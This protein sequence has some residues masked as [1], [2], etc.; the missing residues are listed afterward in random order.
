LASVALIPSKAAAV[1]E[2]VTT[3]NVGTD[4]APRYRGSNPRPSAAPPPIGG[5]FMTDEAP[6]LQ[7]P[8]NALGGYGRHVLIGLMDALPAFEPQREG[9]RVGKVLGIGGRELV[10]VKHA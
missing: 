4:L 2:I 10:V 5:R 3:P 1:I 7:I 9:D 6:A 8:H